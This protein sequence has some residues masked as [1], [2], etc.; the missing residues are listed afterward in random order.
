MLA[1]CSLEKP[2]Y[3]RFRTS[4]VVGTC[5]RNSI[6]VL[7]RLP[8]S[9]SHLMQAARLATPASSSNIALHGPPTTSSFKS[10]ESCAGKVSVHQ[11]ACHFNSLH[12]L[13]QAP[14]EPEQDA[15]HPCAGQSPL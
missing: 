3:S 5:S 12:F 8:G 15:P 4:V 11:M 9:W 14:A 7:L 1:I 13:G 6:A 2:T 10:I